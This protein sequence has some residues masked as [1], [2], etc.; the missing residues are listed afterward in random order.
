MGDVS[1]DDPT[2]AF[3]DPSASPRLPVD[4][5]ALTSVDPSV[6]PHPGTTRQ[7]HPNTPAT[8]PG[9]K[10]HLQQ[11]EGDIYANIRN[12][13]NI[14]YP[15]AS[16]SEFDLANWLSSGALSQK[17]VDSF[18]Y[19]E[20]TKVNP[21]SFNTSKDLQTRIEALPEIPQWYH[22]QIN[23]GS[24]KTKA[25]LM[26]YWRDGLKVVKH[27]FS[28]PVFGPS[29][30]FQPYREY[31]VIDG[32]SQRMY[33]E[34]MSMDVAWGIQDKLPSGHL[35]VGV[36]GASDKT[37]LTIGTGNKEMHPVFI[38]LANIHAGI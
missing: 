36:I 18:L 7:Y 16:K 23:V 2:L 15:F 19:L 35:F 21:P 10:N 12:T 9:G 8:I 24:Y 22:Q 31:K 14:Y 4:N 27:L 32:C 25:P 5:P 37:P 1:V 6:G 28:N 29:M 38:S 30:D 11:M 34:F 13:E 33:G 20:H 17:E 26:L 3:I